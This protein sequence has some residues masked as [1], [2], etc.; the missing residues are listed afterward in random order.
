MTIHPTTLVTGATGK[1]GAAVVARLLELG[2]P[3]RAAVHVDDARAARLRAAGAETVVADIFDPQRLLEAMRGVSRAY[4]CPPWHPYMIQSA[5]AFAVAARQARLEAVVALSQWLASPGH[6]S[7]QTRQTWLADHLFAM[8]PGIAHVTINTGFFA[9]NYLRLVPVAAQLGV[10]PMPTG[11]GRDAPASNEDIARVAVAALIDPRRHGGNIYRP[12]G[13]ALLSGADMAGVL[14]RVLRR[15][16]RFVD[17]PMWMFLRALRVMEPMPAA[18]HADVR[19]YFLEQKRGA[20]E[21][22]APTDHVLQ[23]TG[24][25]AEDFAT[26]AARYAARPEARRTLGHTLSAAGQFL[27]IGFVPGHDLA[28]FVR[29]QNQPV[30]GRPELAAENDAWRAEHLAMVARGVTP[31]L[32][33]V[34]G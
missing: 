32:R 30:A 1:T 20:F 23:V 8:L 27:A 11:Q 2:R 6:P 29:A 12:T 14:T 13:P 9:D 34:A 18:Q 10:L 19:H 4:Y 15:R 24:Q 7:L 16:V 3:V 31:L 25:P 17:V 28:R 5:A 22:G 33:A 26:T 21:L